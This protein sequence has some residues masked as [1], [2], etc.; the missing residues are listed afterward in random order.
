MHLWGDQQNHCM[1]N[2]AAA[3]SGMAQRS[4][5]KNGLKQLKAS[6][7]RSAPGGVVQ[8]VPPDEPSNNRDTSPLPL[9]PP[10][11]Q[12]VVAGGLAGGISPQI[13]AK[14]PPFWPLPFGVPR[15]GPTRCL[16]GTDRPTLPCQPATSTAWGC[17]GISALIF[18][19]PHFS[20]L[21]ANSGDPVQAKSSTR[22]CQK[23]RFLMA[24]LS[25]APNV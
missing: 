1:G 10:P 3:R 2:A 15:T 6:L 19:K 5:N 23:S 25:L 14:T 9:L 21:R 13:T 24:A 17:R 16:Q 4:S 11:F 7:L 12:P 8:V 20:K 18:P 22:C